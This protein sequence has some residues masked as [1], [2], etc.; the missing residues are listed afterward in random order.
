MKPI[1]IIPIIALLSAGCVSRKI[2]IDPISGAPSYTSL[3]FGATET[4]AEVNIT[5]TTN[6]F[7][8]VIK[9]VKS[10]LVSGLEAGVKAGVEGA[11]AG[12]KKP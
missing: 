4:V 5:K 2:K 11:I 8:V 12:M 9:G 3:R 10:D 1:L 6:G 7:T